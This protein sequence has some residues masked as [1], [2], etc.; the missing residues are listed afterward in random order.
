MTQC[1]DVE[2]AFVPQDGLSGGTR[3]GDGHESSLMFLSPA[4]LAMRR[5]AW[6]ARRDAETLGMT[7]SIRGMKQAASVSSL[8]GEGD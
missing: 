6:Q 8:R 7:H 1:K 4:G 2:R 3:E 5:S